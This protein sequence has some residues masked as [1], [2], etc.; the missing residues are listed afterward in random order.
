MSMPAYVIGPPPVAYVRYKDGEPFKY[1]IWG[2][3]PPN[4]LDIVC[5]I[6]AKPLLTGD[7]TSLEPATPSDCVEMDR[8][9]KWCTWVAQE[10]HVTCKFPDWAPE[11]S[12]GH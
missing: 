7:Y 4:D 1:Q 10:F 9:A 5:C 2:P 12:H 3:R 11:E 8:R 6:C